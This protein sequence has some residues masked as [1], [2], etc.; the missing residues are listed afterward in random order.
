LEQ[1]GAERRIHLLPVEVEIQH[2]L[3]VAGHLDL[4]DPPILRH[5]EFHRPVW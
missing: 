1:P 5:H 4:F 3:I 2:R